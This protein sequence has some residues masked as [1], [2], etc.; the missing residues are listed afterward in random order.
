[1]GILVLS[2]KFL[3]VVEGIETSAVAVAEVETDGVVADEFPS[4]DHD[5]FK[6]A[7]RVS[8]VGLPEDVAL[9]LS[10]RAGGNGAQA[11]A[12]VIALCAVGPGDGDL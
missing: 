2:R 7:R 8:A 9:A 11:V 3:Q 12:G 5:A 6:F 4:G 10:L 1:M